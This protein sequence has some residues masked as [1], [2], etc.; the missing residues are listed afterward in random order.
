M[1]ESRVGA[2]FLTALLSA[3]CLQTVAEPWIAG[4]E[5]IPADAATSNPLRGMV[6]EDLNLDGRYQPN[7]PG[8]S[9][10][11]VSNGIDVALSDTHG[12]Y[13]LPVRPD[14]NVFVVQPAGWEVPVDERM[15]PQ[16][17]YIHKEGG[18]PSPLRFGGLP[19]TGS[20]PRQINFPLRKSQ[21][22]S[23]F[24]AG[25][26]GD[27]QTYS[28]R[29]I[30]YFRDSTIKDLLNLDEKSPDFLL[31][32]GDVVGDDLG[33]LDRTIRVGS[34]VGVPQW[35]VHGN[36]DLDFDAAS[37]ADSS[38]TWRRIYGPNYYAF[39]Y[40]E[41]LFV[42]L[43]NVV[44]PCGAQDMARPGRDDCGDPDKPA[45]NGRVP[46]EQMRWLENILA[47]TP[48]EKRI[49]FASHIP[50]VSF[51]DT[52]STRHQTDNLGD[53]YRLVEGRPA[54]S[55][56]GHTHTLENHA[57][58]QFFKGWDEAV[59]IGP[60][61]FRHLIAGAASGAWYNGDLDLH[62]IPMSLQPMGAPKGVLLLD[63]D[64]ADYREQY[65]GNGVEPDRVMWTGLN[66]PGFR[67]WFNTLRAWSRKP[68]SE[69]LQGIPP[70]SINDLGDTQLLTR[71]D[72][73]QG[74]WVTANIWAGSAESK[75]TLSIN[76][77]PAVVMERA[78]SGTGESA[79]TGAEYADPFAAQRQ[80]S[81]SRMA[82]Q[83][84]SGE[85]RHQ[86]YEV[87]KGSKVGPAAP[88]PAGSLT[89]QNMHLWRYRFA[90]DLP[91]GV[92]RATIT[93]TDR[94]GR[95]SH[96]SF[97][98]EVMEN[99]PPPHWRK[100]VW[101]T[102]ENQRPEPIALQR[103]AFG[104]CADQSAPQPIWE[105]IHDSKPDFWIWAGDNIYGDTEDMSVMRAKYAQ[106]AEVPGYAKL[107]AEGVPILATWDDHDYG[108]N[109]GGADY[110]A[111]AASQ[112]A[113]LDFFGVPS[114]SPRRQREGVY[115]A[116]VYG[117]EGRRVQ[118]I[119][120]DTRYH[121][122]AL[123][124][125]PPEDIQTKGRY[126]PN[127]DPSAT[128]LG[129]AQWS[130]LREQLLVPAELRLIVTSIQTISPDH[131]FEKWNNFPLERD[132]LFSLIKETRATGVIF[133][134]GDR[135]HAELSCYHAADAYPLYD[136]T[137]SGINKSQPPA[138]GSPP[139]GLEPNPYRVGGPFQGHHFG[140]VWID[141][142]EP[143]PLLQLAII[144]QRDERPISVQIRL[145]TL[146][147]PE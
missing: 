99:R 82:Y 123:A 48:K 20:A 133:L 19:N 31:F 84:T 30:G 100:E 10:V 128:I 16:F 38:D 21:R 106:L 86:G 72:L 52:T 9:G 117:P 22:A 101:Q 45:Y 25:V 29:E 104:S 23:T 147:W 90:E 3:I 15:V 34:V 121:R 93:S 92:H 102:G 113:F 79:R 32:L 111:R 11:K 76:G 18:S 51:V 141:W 80:L 49:V 125:H 146:Q 73:R 43:D 62:G 65:L 40:G 98:F 139:R 85:P 8:I 137:S 140:T 71:E 36:H 7:E 42:V 135:H 17:F 67:N 136:L 77:S 59:G 75:V 26:I 119:L 78:Q 50:F 14:M 47:L 68:R 24:R 41:A 63:F 129:E 1:N 88:Q 33:L 56:S 83:S 132:R 124:A 46:D 44:Y 145:S 70:L 105:R 2:L 110:P 118:F 6:F 115:H 96:E 54:L 55:L 53:I 134:S 39:E 4:P 28:N 126:Q 94:H 144:N 91:N 120:L 97:V 107:L 35:L 114:D 87:F 142:E 74:V 5:T 37:D 127:T 112:A 103:I 81:V 143:D 89:I 130:W 122:S 60:L 116:E 109:D 13:S 12:E 66:T 27:S 58:G 69:R 64:K 131:R 57:P 108:L 95:V 138:P 61:P